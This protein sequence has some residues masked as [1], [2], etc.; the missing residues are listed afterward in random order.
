MPRPST[1][2][3][4]LAL[5][6][7]NYSKLTLLIKSLTADELSGIFPEKYLNRN[8]RDV[9]AHLHHWHLLMLGWY[10]TG[11]KGEKP[12]IPAKG[13]NWR[14][15]PELNREIRDHYQETSL[16]NV[17]E[18]LQGSFL[19]VQKI[20]NQH[21]ND[22]LFE[23]KRYQWTRNNSLGAYLV[24]STSSHYEWAMKLIKKYLKS[25]KEQTS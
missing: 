1:K 21:S 2:K 15:L 23:R 11:M 20:I 10:E 4:L 18:L 17:L 25:I 24:S 19:E 14:T 9:L 16:A 12:E 7:E 13:Y 5:S 3:D 6:N 22:E 8:I